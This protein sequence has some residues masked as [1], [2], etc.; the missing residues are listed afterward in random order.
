MMD[1]QLCRRFVGNVVLVTGAASGIGA[2]TAVR[3]AGEGALVV[4]TDRDLE[5]A[6]RVRAICP[7]PQ[8]HL[9]LLLDV[10]NENHWRSAL[11]RVK[12]HYDRLDVPINNAGWSRL[13]LIA[14]TSLSDWREILA[15]NLES[16]FLGTKLAMPLLATSGRGAIVNVSSIRSHVAGSGSAAYSSAKSGI[17]M[18]TK[19]S[20]L[21]YAEAGNGV[22][23][24]SVHPGFVSTNFSNGMAS[25]AALEQFAASVPLRRFAKPEEIAAA[26]AFL[27]S[28]DA[29]YISGTELLVDGAFTA[30]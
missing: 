11:D 30:R 19:V 22:R 17:R 10:T 26:I 3:L 15:V 1:R 14:D 25:T 29:S 24:N 27:A 9:A 12:A 8:Q 6:E 20:A 4:L 13:Q 7:E 16:V 2:A 5:G 23:V 28:E 21:E 18:L